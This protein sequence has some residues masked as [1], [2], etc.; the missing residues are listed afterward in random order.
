M[1]EFK[2]T[3]GPWSDP[4]MY[5]G[6]GLEIIGG[7]KQVCVVP[8][9]KIM[10]GARWIGTEMR[11]RAME[12]ARLIAAAPELLAA[13]ETFIKQWNACGPNSDFGR[14]F[15]SVRDQARAALTKATER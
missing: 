2:G 9:I 12:D 15:S 5:G 6:N 10:E 13:L 3:P 4:S 1:G 14:Y 8:A 11:D 7:G